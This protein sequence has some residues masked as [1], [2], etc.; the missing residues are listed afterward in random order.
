MTKEELLLWG[1]K[2]V[3]LYNKI[4]DERGRENTP[5]FYTQS[6]LNKIIGVNSVDI[7][8]AGINPGSGGVLYQIYFTSFPCA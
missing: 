4:A 7:L 8:I 5:E 1:E 3:Q 2:T 6:D